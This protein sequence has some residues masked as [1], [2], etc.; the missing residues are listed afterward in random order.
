MSEWVWAL[1][2]AAFAA[3]NSAAW[4][5]RWAPP[6]QRLFWGVQSGGGYGLATVSA[7]KVCQYMIQPLVEL[8]AGRMVVLKVS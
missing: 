4:L 8:Y 6:R 2:R 1:F 3:V 7:R 5:G